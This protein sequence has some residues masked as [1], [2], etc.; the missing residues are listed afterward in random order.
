[1]FREW[2][3]RW[4]DYSVMVDLARIPR[5]KQLIQMRMCLTLETQRLLEHTLDI[6]PS[7]DMTVDQVLDRL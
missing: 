5:E 4:E 3:C 1:M 6:P 7:T 2:C